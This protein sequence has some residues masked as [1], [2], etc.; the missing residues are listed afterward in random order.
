MSIATDDTLIYFG[1]KVKV[2]E[3]GKVGGYLIRYTPEGDLDLDEERFSK[4]TNLGLIDGGSLPVFYNHGYDEVLKNRQIGRGSIKF[5]DIGVWVQAQLD[6]RDEYEKAIYELAEAEKLGWSSGAA[7][8]LVDTVAEEK[9]SLITSWIIAEAS[10]TPTPAEFRNAAIPVKKWLGSLD[11]KSK[12][13]EVITMDENTTQAPA[14]VEQIDLAAL[15]GLITDSVKTAVSGAMEEAAKKAP[16]IKAGRVDVIEDEVDKRVKHDDFKSNG[17]FLMAVKQAALYPSMMD[18]RLLPRADKTIAGANETVPSEGGF[19]VLTEMQ[20]SVFQHMWGEGS[21]LSLFQ[22]THKLGPNFNSTKLPAIDETSRADGSRRGGITAYWLPEGTTVAITK[23]KFNR[24][25]LVLKKLGALCVA[26]DEVL[27]DAVQLDSWLTTNVPL[28]LTFMVEDALIN[29]S[30]IGEPL[31]ILNSNALIQATRVNA[32]TITAP[33]IANMWMH[34]YVSAPDYVWLASQSIHPQLVAMT[35][36]NMPVYLPPG[37]L[38]GSQYGTIYGRPVYETEYNPYLGTV[39]D[40]ILLAPSQYYIIEKGRGIE[41]ASSMHVYFDSFQMAFR[42][43]YR[44]DG[45]PMW[46]SSVTANDGTNTIS[47]YIA[48]AATT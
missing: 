41:T 14:K 34:R 30:G 25:S 38:S 12:D 20:T 15:A 36:G 4:N 18:K 44:I 32:S 33:D 2:L 37:G 6:L 11:K 21:L 3:N 9:G 10:L 47:P 42:F 5:D 46:L 7:G 48:L 31:G 43:M 28:E 17:E 23:P 1:D 26:T 24:I 8:H 45:Q 27:Q 19:L 40:L 13:Q 22:P 29:G 16:P 39:G 35:V